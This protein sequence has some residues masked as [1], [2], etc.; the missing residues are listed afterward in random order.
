PAGVHDRDRIGVAAF[1]EELWVVEDGEGAAEAVHHDAPV[2]RGEYPPPT[3][4]VG[5]VGGEVVDVGEGAG[6]LEGGHGDGVRLAFD[7][8]GGQVRDGQGGVGDGDGAAG[9]GRDEGQGVA[10]DG[11]LD[12]EEARFPDDVGIKEAENALAEVHDAAVGRGER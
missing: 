9:A 7:G 6:V 4:V 1:L 3:G 11:Q 8:V 2:G 5:D 10:G 12:G